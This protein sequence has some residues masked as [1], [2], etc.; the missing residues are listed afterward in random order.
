MA[1]NKPRRPSARKPL[2]AVTGFFCLIFAAL[3]TAILL[4]VGLVPTLAAFIIDRTPGKFLMKCVAG[5]NVAGL[6]PWIYKLWMNG[7]DMV[8]AMDM[9]TDIFMW[10]SIYAASGMGWALFLGLP[11]AVAMSRVLNAKRRIYV[12]RERQ[13]ALFGEW[14]EC[15]LPPSDQRMLAEASQE[16]GEEAIDPRDG[17]QDGGSAENAAPPL[18]SNQAA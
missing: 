6:L 17:E 15:I 11:S 13:K 8:T 10:F 7:H 12:L 3:P 18:G 14:G 16:A 5:M 9:S 2:L 4:I 1:E